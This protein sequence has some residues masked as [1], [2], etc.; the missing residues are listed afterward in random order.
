MPPRAAAAA[1]VA[2]RPAPARAPSPPSFP[3]LRF[4]FFS[5]FFT[6]PGVL[7]G[8]PQK[9]APPPPFF[10][11]FFADS[12]RRR[13]ARA[14]G[15]ACVRARRRRRARA[16]RVRRLSAGTP[17]R[18]PRAAEP[19]PAESRPG[20]WRHKRAADRAR[21]PAPRICRHRS[22]ARRARARARIRMMA[23]HQKACEG[24]REQRRIGSK[25]VARAGG[26]GRG[27]GGGRIVRS[28]RPGG[29]PA[30]HTAASGRARAT[31]IPCARRQ[32]RRRPHTAHIHSPTCTA[33][34]GLPACGPEPTPRL[35]GATDG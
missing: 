3:S 13:R 24:P 6:A 8:C 1:V 19:R 25:G 20:G 29:T 5:S 16:T 11:F 21:A 4:F 32:R 26:G 27:E 14:R 2:P 30:D 22:T 35:V 7:V 18:G 17:N 15:H 9:K 33:K 34:P 12:A 10:F 28:R 31:E 23:S